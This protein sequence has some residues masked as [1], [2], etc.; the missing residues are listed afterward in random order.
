[1]KLVLDPAQSM[2]A[3]TADDFARKHDPVGRLRALRD[4]RD[5]LAFSPAV[6]AE[7]ADLGWTGIPFAEADGGLGMG[8]AEVVL[9]T[10]ALGRGLA[11][12]PYVSAV[13]FAGGI[14]ADVG[15]A[16]QR[17]A[18]LAPTVNG[19]KRLAV[20]QHDGSGRFDLRRCGTTAT[21]SGGSW[22]LQGS[23]AHVIDGF[24]ADGYVVVARTSGEENDR[25]GISLFLVPADRDGVRVRRQWRVDSRNAALVDLEGVVVQQSDLLGEVG[26]GFAPL[27]AATDRATV[28]LCGEMLGMAREAFERTLEY[29]KTRE[30]FGA[31]I[32]SFQALQHR[33]AEIFVE[34]ELCKSVVMAAARTLDEESED[35]AESRAQVC[36]AKARCSDTLILV[37][38]EALQMHGGVGMT[39]EYDIGLFMK[40]ARV[41]ELSF[42]D[43]SYHRDRFARVRGF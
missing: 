15:T 20:A 42:G 5:Q 18:W 2:L 41:C 24:G 36:N 9:I 43:A 34:I 7:M 12:E 38:N 13:V 3:K 8:M 19:E 10:E 40:R 6:W 29:L 17:A 14:L 28:A 23:K 26:N 31:K 30:Q 11:P 32:G 25:A 33:A 35:S 1:M 21:A 39:D 4:A 16:E 27:R 37:T 22:T